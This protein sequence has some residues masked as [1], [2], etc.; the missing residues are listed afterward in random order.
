MLPDDALLEIFDFYVDQVQIEAWHT[1]VHVCRNWRNVVFGSPRRL[2]LRLNCTARTPVRKMLDIWPP[3]PIVIRASGDKISGV[4]EELDNIFAALKHKDRISA[5]DFG[6]I[7]LGN[8]LAEMEQPFP[9]LQALTLEG[10]VAP[11]VPGLPNLLSSATHLVHLILRKIPFYGLMSPDAMVTCLSVLTRL[12]ELVIEFGCRQRLKSQRRPPSTRTLLPVLTK[13]RFRGLSEYLEDVAARIDAPLLE[14]LGI[15]F[16]PQRGFNTP[17]LS[18]FISRT[19][20]FNTHD[21]DEAHLVSSDNDISVTLPQTSDGALKLGISPRWDLSSLAQVC[22]SSFP[23][24]HAVE[25][26]Y[27]ID[28]GIRLELWDP[29]YYTTWPELFQVFTAVKNLYIL[30]L[31][32]PSIAPILPEL[33]VLPALQTL[34]LEDPTHFQELTSQFVTARQ[35][36]GHPVAISRWERVIE[37][38]YVLIFVSST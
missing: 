9:A 7:R 18:Q 35:L 8:V 13:L 3:L 32:L 30:S 28:D 27:I 10:I 37:D 23:H 20:K 24:I 26:L 22:S 21:S 29:Q 6:H 4:V 19:P 12:D 11:I 33:V 15:T 36:A 34:Y 14:N 25:H 2:N 17:Q 31:F 1:L 38:S 5:I 16:F